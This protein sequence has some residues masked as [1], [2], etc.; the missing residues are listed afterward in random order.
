MAVL[1]ISRAWG[2]MSWR[3]R[4][5]FRRQGEPA[6]GRV[7]VPAESVGLHRPA[8]M[9]CRAR[10]GPAAVTVAI[11]VG[12]AGEGDAPS[13][14]L[15]GPLALLRRKS[16]ALAWNGPEPVATAASG[17]PE[18]INPC[19]GHLQW[20]MEKNSRAA[21]QRMEAI[22]MCTPAWRR[23]RPPYEGG[24]VGLARR[25][26]ADATQVVR[27]VVGRCPQASPVVVV[28]HCDWTSKWDARTP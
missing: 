7:D 16:R 4:R 22:R 14:W 2:N 25:P 24:P 27:T 26:F 6:A 1:G 9:D 15:T 28:K 18:V 8:G 20:L 23:F 13:L 3:G 12:A 11:C 10:H 19:N 17:G 21:A 5:S